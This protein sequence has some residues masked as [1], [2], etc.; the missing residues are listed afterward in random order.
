LS[1]AVADVSYYVDTDKEV[2]F[3]FDAIRYRRLGEEI[4][5]IADLSLEDLEKAP[6]FKSLS[7]A[8]ALEDMRGVAADDDVPQR[9]DEPRATSQ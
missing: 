2:A 6:A 7:D 4:R 8:T 9:V 5:L 1:V 3:E